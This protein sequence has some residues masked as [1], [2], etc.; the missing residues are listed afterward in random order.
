MGRLKSVAINAHASSC[1]KGEGDKMPC[2]EDV[3][4]ELKV[5]EVTTT[6]FDF[7][8]QPDLYQIAV[9]SFVLTHEL[10]VDTDFN[11]FSLWEPPLPVRD[12]QVI[13][14]SFLI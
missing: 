1:I 14:Q 8:L 3:Q 5:E 6:S 12:I 4:Q 10:T 11:T 2:C 7:H 9:I 13:Y